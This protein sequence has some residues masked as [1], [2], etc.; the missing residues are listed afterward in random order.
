MSARYKEACSEA[1]APCSTEVARTECRRA[2]KLADMVLTVEAPS[3]PGFESFSKP[4]T[5]SMGSGLRRC[6]SSC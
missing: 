3:E 2:A 1:N 6:P 4:I 5:S